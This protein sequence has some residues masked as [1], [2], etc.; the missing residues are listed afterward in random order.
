VRRDKRTRGKIETRGQQ[1]KKKR[2][3][4]EGK[5]DEWP[6]WEKAITLQAKRGENLKSEGIRL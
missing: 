5:S 6:A 2:L 3:S 4:F 1:R